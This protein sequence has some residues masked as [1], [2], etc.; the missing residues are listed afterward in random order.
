[1]KVE[2]GENASMLRQPLGVGGW[3]A[4]RTAINF[5]ENG[6]MRQPQQVEALFAGKFFY[7][8]CIRK[9]SGRHFERPFKQLGHYFFSA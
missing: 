7:G 6:F 9:R 5:R 4:K 8:G 2:S 3:C 1:M